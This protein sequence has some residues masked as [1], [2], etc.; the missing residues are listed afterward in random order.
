MEQEKIVTKKENNI[1][2]YVIISL[3]TIIILTMCIAL[4]FATASKISELDKDENSEKPVFQETVT[5]KITYTLKEY[6]GKIGVYQNDS[7]IYTLDKYVFTLP[8][9]DKK[10]LDEGIEFSNIEELYIAIEEYY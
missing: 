6:N 3:N 1:L 4:Y 7:L 5:E 2:L 9:K 8:E 10:L